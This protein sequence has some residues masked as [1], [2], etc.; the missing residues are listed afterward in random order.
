KKSLTLADGFSIT[1]YD[2]Q[3]NLVNINAAD[4]NVTF[5]NITL[6]TGKIASSLGGNYIFSG[7]T[8]GNATMTMVGQGTVTYNRNGNQNVYLGIYSGELLLTGSGT[9]TLQGN[10]TT[11][12]GIRVQGSEGSIVTLDGNNKIVDGTLSASWATIQKTNFNTLQTINSYNGTTNTVLGENNTNLDIHLTASQV[13]GA[14]L[15]YGIP[16]N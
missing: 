2:A 3:E 6:N 5:G 15:A 12:N 1:G 14:D 9:K 8:S 4:A 7:T 11:Q 16:L 13:K 10:I